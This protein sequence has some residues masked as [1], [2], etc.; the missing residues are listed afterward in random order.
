MGTFFF[1]DCTPCGI[2]WPKTANRG[3][4][5]E[6]HAVRKERM[7][8]DEM[9]KA[10]RAIR[11]N[12]VKM[13]KCARQIAEHFLDVLRKAEMHVDDVHATLEG[14]LE[15]NDADGAP[16]SLSESEVSHDDATAGG[17]S[18]QPEAQS[19]APAQVCLIERRV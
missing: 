18:G 10:M 7:S 16:V 6:S 3:K 19:F 15:G 1:R 5:L 17:V 9:L 13:P 8:M 11:A 4:I 14:T 2:L 12:K